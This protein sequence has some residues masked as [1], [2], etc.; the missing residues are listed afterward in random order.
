[1]PQ[2]Q[3]AMSQIINSNIKKMRNILAGLILAFVVISCS[4]DPKTPPVST[5]DNCKL[6][7]IR[8]EYNQKV[9]SYEYS[10]D[11]KIEKIIRF[12]TATGTV[13]GYIVFDYKSKQVDINHYNS[14]NQFTYSEFY[15]LNDSGWANMKVTTK[16]ADPDTTYFEY[17]GQGYL[18]KSIGN[19]IHFSSDTLY[20]GY[21]DGKRL[22]FTSKGKPHTIDSVSYEYYDFKI[23][24]NIKSLLDN[25]YEDLGDPVDLEFFL[26][27]TTDYALKSRSIRYTDDPN[28]IV[29]HEFTYEFD[30]D[31]KL[32]NIIGTVGYKNSYTLH[33]F[34]MN[35]YVE[36]Q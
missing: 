6:K 11:N 17:D 28:H 29:V 2:P 7:E 32:T 20:Y 26:G 36:C 5:D 13:Q 34:E 24:S 1:M 14:S 22:F 30:S 9:N 16:G 3:W 27:K 18:I 10:S 4:K 12:D 35:F 8:N 31:N 19:A 15:F 25:K 33:S 21:E 23:P